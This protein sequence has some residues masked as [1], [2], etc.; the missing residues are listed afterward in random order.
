MR[1]ALSQWRP[2]VTIA[3]HEAQSIFFSL[4]SDPDARI[5]GLSAEHCQDDEVWTWGCEMKIYGVWHSATMPD[6][7]ADGAEIHWA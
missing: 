6:H 3:R 2:V 4:T 5:R 1:R 7:W